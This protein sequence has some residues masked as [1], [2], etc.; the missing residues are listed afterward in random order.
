MIQ[1]AI[2]VLKYLVGEKI[3]DKMQGKKGCIMHD[4]FSLYGVHYFA[5]IAQYTNTFNKEGECEVV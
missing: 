1:E 3:K 5:V 2:I 4:G